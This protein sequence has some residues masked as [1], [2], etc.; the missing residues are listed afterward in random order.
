MKQRIGRKTKSI[1]FSV[2]YKK[3]R[4]NI[5]VD[6]RSNHTEMMKKAIIKGLIMLIKSLKIYRK[7]LPKMDTPQKR[8]GIISLI[9][10][11]KSLKIKAVG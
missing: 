4:T 11:Q 10:R 1:E 9:D 5:N 3:T 6:A 8:F 7:I 2:N